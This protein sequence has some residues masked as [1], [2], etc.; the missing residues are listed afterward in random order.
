MTKRLT[1]L[2]SEILEVTV[3]SGRLVVESGLYRMPGQ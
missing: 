3:K 1:D 2:L